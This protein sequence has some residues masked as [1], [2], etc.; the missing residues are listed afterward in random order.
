MDA[1]KQERANA[2]EAESAGG[3]AG[4]SVSG[5]VARGV[6]SSGDVVGFGGS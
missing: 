4:G 1:V 3:R 5:R 2:V 6:F